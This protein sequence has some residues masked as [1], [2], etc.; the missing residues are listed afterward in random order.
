M[1]KDSLNPLGSELVNHCE[2]LFELEPG[3]ITNGNSMCSGEQFRDAN[4]IEPRPLQCPQRGCVTDC[5]ERSDSRCS[6]TTAYF[7]RGQCIPT[8]DGYTCSCSAPKKKD[9]SAKSDINPLGIRQDFFGT[10]PMPCG[11]QYVNSDGKST[12]LAD[13]QQAHNQYLGDVPRATSGQ[14]KT[15]LVDLNTAV[16]YS[17]QVQYK[18]TKYNYCLNVQSWQQGASTMYKAYKDR[19]STERFDYWCGSEGSQCPI[20]AVNKPKFGNANFTFNFKGDDPTK[21]QFLPDSVDQYQRG[22]GIVG[23]V[24]SG[25]NADGS[26]K[27]EGYTDQSSLN[28]CQP[29]SNPSEG[30]S[31]SSTVTTKAN[32]WQFFNLLAVWRGIICDETD[33]KTDE[34]QQITA[35]PKNF[36]MIMGVNKGGKK[37]NIFQNWYQFDDNSGCLT[38]SQHAKSCTTN[39]DCPYQ[40]KCNTAV[41][42]CDYSDQTPTLV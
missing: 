24:I 25:T 2:D 18:N 17:T 38:D 32:F 15:K 37:R 41:K 28:V 1:C 10:T 7:S 12:F 13:K 29:Y 14:Q 3:I 22:M 34:L 21:G 16:A 20:G 26:P 39:G 11:M 5:Y 36:P 30:D 8:P 40:G 4:D 19:Q 9:L 33:K 31:F 42:R 35:R 6:L 27:I 23:K